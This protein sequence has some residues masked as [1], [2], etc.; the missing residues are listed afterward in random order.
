MH[1]D[2]PHLSVFVAEVNQ[3]GHV[4]EELNKVVQD[5]QDQTQT[6]QTRRYKNTQ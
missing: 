6:V 5:K 3:A 1:R 2:S 4:K